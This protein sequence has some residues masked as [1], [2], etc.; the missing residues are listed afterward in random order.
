MTLKLPDTVA[1]TG[2]RRGVWST[3]LR[4]HELA[5][6]AGRTSSSSTA[7]QVLDLPLRNDRRRDKAACIQLFRL[8]TSI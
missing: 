8:E 2:P 7:A 4:R 5:A 1:D 6:W 3:G